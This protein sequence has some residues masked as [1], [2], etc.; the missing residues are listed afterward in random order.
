MIDIL[1]LIH[2]HKVSLDEAYDLFDAAQAAFHRGE[3]DATWNEALGLSNNEATAFLHGASLGDLA[4]LRY[5]GWPT[6][7]CRCHRPLDYRAYGW[8]F[9]RDKEGRPSLR[10]IECPITI[11]EDTRKGP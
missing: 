11:V 5:A 2:K 10:H 3:S 6:T 1:A 4:S 8:W 7:C 9:V